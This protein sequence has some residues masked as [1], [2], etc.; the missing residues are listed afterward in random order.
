MSKFDYMGFGYDGGSDDMFVAH[1]KKY[2]AAEAVENA[3][4]GIG[5]VTLDLISVDLKD[6]WDI[7]GEITGETAS[8][9]IISTVFEKFCVGK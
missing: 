1:A 8:E 3:A 9:E 4:A 5:A 6:V 2:S 7:L